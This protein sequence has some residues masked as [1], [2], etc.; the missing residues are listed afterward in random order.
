MEQS[1]FESLVHSIKEAIAI[2][3]QRRYEMNTDELLETIREAERFIL[4]SREL[5]SA[6]SKR[7]QYRG[8]NLPKEQGAVKRASMDLTRALAELRK[9]K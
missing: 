5:I 3:K 2:S 6:R 1:L 8:E 4:K 9:P 7:S